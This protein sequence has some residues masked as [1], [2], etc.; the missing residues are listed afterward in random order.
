MF[1]KATIYATHLCNKHAKTIKAL[2]NCLLKVLVYT[3]LTY[4]KQ[5][6]I[7][8]RSYTYMFQLKFDVGCTVCT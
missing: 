5:V 2:P 6:A 8:I 4:L 7:Y 3:Q 1:E